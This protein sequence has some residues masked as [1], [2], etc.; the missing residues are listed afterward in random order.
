[1]NYHETGL[2]DP[3]TVP[4]FQQSHLTLPYNPPLLHGGFSPPKSFAQQHGASL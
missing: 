3:Y 2:P 1:M 4:S